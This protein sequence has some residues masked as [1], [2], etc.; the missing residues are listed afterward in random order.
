MVMKPSVFTL[1]ALLIPGI[2]AGQT[3]PDSAAGEVPHAMVRAAG[4]PL[5][6]GELPPGVLTV[7]VVRGDFSNNLP[8]QPVSVEVVGGATSTARTAPDGRAQFPHLGV[9]VRV[10]ASA[11]VDG[12]R[13]ESELIEMPTESG[14]RVLLVAGGDASSPVG[15]PALNA[16]LPP[17]PIP[18]AAASTAAAEP[19]SSTGVTVVKTVLACATLFAAA[20]FLWQRRT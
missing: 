1:A 16:A 12:E 19:P 6:D 8:D 11:V 14:V 9:G 13:L 7:R 20:M 17:A 3:T 2:C 15:Q 4:M 18:P 10:K 5:R